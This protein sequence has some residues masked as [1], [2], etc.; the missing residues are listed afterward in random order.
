MVELLFVAAESGC[1]V[2]PSAVMVDRR[3]MDMQ[4]LVEY[5]VIDDV[6]RN[7]H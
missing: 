2:V 4:H 7:I 6:L 3:V 5:D 1:V